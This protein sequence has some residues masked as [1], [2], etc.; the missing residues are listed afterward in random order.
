VLFLLAIFIHSHSLWVLGLGIMA[1]AALA[2]TLIF[3]RST[4]G[5]NRWLTRASVS[6]AIILAV[7]LVVWTENRPPRWAPVV[8]A[9]LAA[10]AF[11]L[12]YLWWRNERGGKPPSPAGG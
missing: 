10:G 2:G 8:S 1:V 11:G 6:V 12:A 7:W 5:R 4:N 3:I 9:L